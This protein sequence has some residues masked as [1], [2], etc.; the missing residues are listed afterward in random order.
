MKSSMVSMVSTRP[1]AEGY[2]P[3]PSLVSAWTQTNSNRRGAHRERRRRRA[4]R[5][6]VGRAGQTVARRRGVTRC[7]A[8]KGGSKP[9]LPPGGVPRR[10]RRVE[11]GRRQGG[12]AARAATHG[13]CGRPR[14][15]ESARLPRPARVAGAERRLGRRRG[16]RE[17]GRTRGAS[18]RAMPSRCFSPPLRRR[19]RSPTTVS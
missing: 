11:D 16:A 15:G 8:R 19:P 14:A 17:A 18:A 3:S 2:L 10:R 1:Q 4:D 9:G 12:L 5:V 7:L 6:R 13:L